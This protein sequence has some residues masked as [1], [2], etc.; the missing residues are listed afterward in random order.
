MIARLS[1]SPAPEHGPASGPSDEHNCP[2]WRS[3]Y[4]VNIYQNSPIRHASLNTYLDI[5]Q[6]VLRKVRRPLSPQAILDIAYQM[7][8][9]PAQLHGRTQHKTL[10]ARLSEDIVR[11][12]YESAFFRTEPGIFFLRE[13][14]TDPS[15]PES[16][17]RPVVTR[18]R[19]RELYGNQVLYAE[20]SNDNFLTSGHN[21]VSPELVLANLEKNKFPYA[22]PRDS[23]GDR[24]FVWSAAI[25]RRN[26]A[27]LCYRIGRYRDQ[28]DSFLLKRTV[29]FST[30]VEPK[31]R[32]LFSTDPYG[33]A[34]SGVKAAKIDLDIEE[35]PTLEPPTIQ[36]FVASYENER[37]S[38]LV[39]VVYFDCPESFEP[40]KRRLAMHD[41]HWLNLRHPVN[42]L[43]D[44]DPWSQII[45]EHE[46]ECNPPES[47]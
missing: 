41:V 11:R 32:S 24:V 26:D 47:L 25:V 36:Y 44:F 5:A 35:L 6:A 43:S 20:K 28:R 45:L 27:I 42:D 30:M 34:E 38:D 17:K 16:Y 46:F 22:N 4:D 23:S 8:I 10:H 1:I 13:F 33:I 40:T 9:V 3:D 18:R 14:L 21:I 29:G 19:V 2:L 12:R 15:L 31:D 7:E 39:G 37:L